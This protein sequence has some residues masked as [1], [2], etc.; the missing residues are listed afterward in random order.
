M[1]ISFKKSKT[2]GMSIRASGK[3]AQALFDAMT[4]KKPSAKVLNPLVQVAEFNNLVQVGQEVDYRSDPYAEPVRFKTRCPAEVL[5][6]HTAV[7]WLEG[8]SGCVSLESLTVVQNPHCSLRG[9]LPGGMCPAV[10]V[11]GRECTATG[12]CEYQVKA[13]AV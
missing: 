9:M 3:D 1:S 7:V 12:Y 11:G 5:S 6:G 2:G 4:S 13:G 8:K 10:M